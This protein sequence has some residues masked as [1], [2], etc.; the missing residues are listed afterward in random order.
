MELGYEISL[1]NKHNSFTKKV[2]QK[3]KVNFS[4]GVLGTVNYLNQIQPHIS[5]RLGK[6]LEQ[7]TRL[8]KC[9]YPDKTSK[10]R[11]RVFLIPMRTAI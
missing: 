8:S 4:G 10:D 2:S 11:Y 6:I 3:V 9:F 7:I 1:K 5:D